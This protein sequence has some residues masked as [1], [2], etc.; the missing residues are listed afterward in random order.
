MKYKLYIKTNKY[1]NALRQDIE[2][3]KKSIYIEMYIFL[4]DT[5][6][7]HD[8]VN[9][10]VKKAKEWVKI[11]VV[12]DAFWSWDLSDTI[13]EKFRQAWIDFNFFSDWFRR[14][15]RK[16]IIIDHQ[17]VFFGGANIKNNS[18]HWIDL[19]IR[20]K[21]TLIVRQIIR[22]FAYTYKMCGWKDPQI[23]A[24]YKKSL[25]Q[26]LKLYVLSNLPWHKHYKL[27]NYYKEKLIQAKKSIKITTPYFIP[28]RRMLALFDDAIR[29]GVVIEIIVPFDTDVKLLNKI[30]RYY[31]AKLLP[32]GIIFYAAKQM[33]HAK[34][35]IIDNREICIWSQNIDNLS[36]LHNLEIGI[37]S[38]Q[39]TLV[40]AILHIFDQWKKK[41]NY[42]KI[43]YMKI[44]LFDK[45]IFQFLKLLFYFM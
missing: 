42:Y 33:N 5:K 29:R 9:L 16:I 23:L 19:Q 45:I 44:S 38:R 37:F 11:V 21:D 2:K 6:E 18:R 15:H 3:A 27:T 8:F 34:M 41:S 24:Y 40:T 36:M 14:T 35:M 26:A 7:S 10:L 32:L 30:N 4:D 17:I 39:K 22:T 25:I 1:W 31:I 20:I 12:L 13:I 28:P 43:W